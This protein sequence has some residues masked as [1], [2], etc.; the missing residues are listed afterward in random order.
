[1]PD[2]LKRIAERLADMPD[3][4]PAQAER[5]VEPVVDELIHDA[6]ERA[7]QNDK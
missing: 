1:M 5:L 6:A 3:L 2:A 4:T 7:R